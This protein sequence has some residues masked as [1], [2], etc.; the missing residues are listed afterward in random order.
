MNRPARS[1]VLAAVSVLG[2][3]S[4]IA[5]DGDDAGGAPAGNAGSSTGGSTSGGGTGGG[6]G[7]D[8][9]A[10]AGGA[11]AQGFGPVWVI[12]KDF[13]KVAVLDGEGTEIFSDAVTSEPLAL[14]LEG[15]NAW[16][17][18]EGGEILRY[19]VAARARKATITGAKKPQRLAA[20]GNAAW[21]VDDTGAPCGSTPDE[22]PRKLHRVD[23]TTDKIASTTNLNLDEAV[24]SCDETGALVAD[25]QAA[26][27]IMDNGF[28]AIRVT[29]DG[30][31][32]LRAKLGLEGGYGVGNGALTGTTLWVVDRS[33][34]RLLDLDPA[35]LAQR[36]TVTLPDDVNADVMT[37]SDKAV[38]LRSSA[39]ILRIDAAATSTSKAITLEASA[40]AFARSTRGLYVAGGGELGAI[41]ILD[42]VTGE[43]KGEI[44]L[45]YADGLAVP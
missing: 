36:A 42:A 7:N 23:G 11:D 14:A 4:A 34:K 18:L 35:T 1:G 26:Y 6:A 8:T 28:G 44:P 12:K 32:A 41:V 29:N 17:I 21:V 19:D 45:A 15:N 30:K 43:K 10:G 40:D 16:V 22:G 2:L 27:A 5:C 3:L 39:G 24:G 33:K 13:K 38:W 9:G 25:G 31:I 20:A 37:A